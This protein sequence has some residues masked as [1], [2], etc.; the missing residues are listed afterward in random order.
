VGLPAIKPG[1]IP[2]N[3][4]RQNPDGVFCASAP[5]ISTQHAKQQTATC[6]SCRTDI[7]ASVRSCWS[8]IPD[9]SEMDD[10]ATDTPCSV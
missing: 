5:C 10:S 1:Q 7:D 3:P 2:K 4:N 8:D 9:T 6:G